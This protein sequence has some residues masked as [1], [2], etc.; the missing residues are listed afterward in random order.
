MT[1]AAQ[2]DIQSRELRNHLEL[3]LGDANELTPASAL[4]IAR[5][6]LEYIGRNAPSKASGQPPPEPV[7]LRRAEHYILTH[8]E[9]AIS[10]A[11]LAAASGVSASMLYSSFRAHR[12]C[13]PMARVREHRLQLARSRLLAARELNVA[14]VAF[15]CGFEHLGR[16][17]VRYRKRFGESP[18]QT[19]RRA[20]A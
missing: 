2:L 8:A 14:Q 15:A 3:L 20:R 11:D 12:G 1:E 10:I 16:F 7:H 4:D 5:N 13:S 17:S 19:L 6:M 18:R 9:D